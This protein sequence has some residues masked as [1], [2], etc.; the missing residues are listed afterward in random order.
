[1]AGVLLAVTASAGPAG[2]HV[3][4]IGAEPEVD[5][6]VTEGEDGVEIRF[7]ALDPSAPVE[8][9]V[10]DPAGHDVTAGEPEVDAR[11]STVSVPTKPLE[12]GQHIVHWHAASDDGD[13]ESEGTFRFDVVDAP[14]D[15]WG[16]WLIWIVGLAIPAAVFLRPGARKREPR[17]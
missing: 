4:V 1:M 9:E 8:I 15:G 11:T 10:T 12:A 14:G 13:G 16:I 5:G 2:A 17:T 7:A 3:E 6:E